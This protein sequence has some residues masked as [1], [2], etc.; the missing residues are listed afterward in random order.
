MQN[1]YVISDI[2]ACI[3][4]F[5]SMLKKINFSKEDLLIIN[6][7]IIDRGG[8]NNLS[9]IKF[10]S[11]FNNIILLRGN[12]EEFFLRWDSKEL[13]ERDW[14]RFGG[15]NTLFEIKNMNIDDFLFF[16]NFIVKTKLFY[17]ISINGVDYIISH[18]G[19]NV[20]LN[21]IYDKDNL[22]N[23][24]SS[25]LSMYEQDWFDFFVSSDI[26]Y[27]THL[28]FD[29]FPIV[30]HVPTIQIIDEPKIFRHSKYFDIDCGCSYKGGR[31]G[32]LRLNDLQEFYV[33]IDKNDLI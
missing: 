20:D 5:K 15:A 10:I 8:K 11:T 9:I 27:T 12:H 2:H 29:K 31:L 21:F 24:S 3:R 33:N 4:T 30:G 22:I 23:L 16:R 7:D 17:E 32:C 28:K 18:N 25:I 14:Y 1:I 19:Y 26:H 13:A 6:G